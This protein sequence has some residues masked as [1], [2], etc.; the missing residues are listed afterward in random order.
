MT[1]NPR[2]L[3]PAV[4]LLVLGAIAVYP[5]GHSQATS[6]DQSQAAQRPAAPTNKKQAATVHNSQPEDEGERVFRQNCSRCHTAPDGF[7]SR[8][9][10][11]VVRHMRVRASLSQHDEEALLRFF[12]P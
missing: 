5:Q 7:S 2:Y 9:S 3:L 10:G 12:N 6:Q 11:T 1:V 4:F 8:I